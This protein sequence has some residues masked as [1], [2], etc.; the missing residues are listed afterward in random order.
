MKGKF[1]NFEEILKKG[2]NMGGNLPDFPDAK[3]VNPLKPEIPKAFRTK[4][5][6]KI[7]KKQGFNK[8]AGDIESSIDK[9]I[10]ENRF[11][12]DNILF[13]IKE[14]ESIE[15]GLKL[16]ITEESSGRISIKWAVGEGQQYSIAK[17]LGNASLGIKLYLLPKEGSKVASAKWMDLKFQGEIILNNISNNTAMLR[18]V[19]V[20]KFK[21]KEINLHSSPRLNRVN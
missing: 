12:K 16:N 18:C 19:L 4:A 20:L 14:S 17:V 13:D 10:Y 2:F 11:W 15:F 9:I 5:M 3:E 7:L 21:E 6:A 8:E 1:L